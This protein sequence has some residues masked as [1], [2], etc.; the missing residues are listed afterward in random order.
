MNLRK[1]ALLAGMALAA[2]AFAVPATA[3]AEETPIWLKNHDPLTEHAELEFAGTAQFETEEGG[4]H[5][6][7]T[8]GHVTAEPP[9]TGVVTAFTVETESCEGFGLLEGCELVDH[10][11][12]NEPVGHATANTDIEITEVELWNE[13]AGSGCPV[14]TIELH[15]P[16]VTLTPENSGSHTEAPTTISTVDLHAE[17]VATITSFFHLIHEEEDV[18]AEGTL[19]ATDGSEIYGIGHNR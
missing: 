9:H 15:L 6:N 13:F 11:L 3:S 16:V 18:T 4:I 8:E 12:T 17:G 19:E 10:E 7:E 14:E 2:I 5:C 1:M